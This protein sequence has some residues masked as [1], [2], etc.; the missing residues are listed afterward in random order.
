MKSNIR[1]VVPGAGAF[2]VAAFS[3]LEEFKKKIPG[4]ARLGVEIFAKALLVIPKVLRAD[5]GRSSRVLGYA[6]QSVA[7]NR[8]LGV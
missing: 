1:A 8:D 5:V 4:K 2:E 7:L 6:S 3:R